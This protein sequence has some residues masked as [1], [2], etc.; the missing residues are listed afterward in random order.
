MSIAGE[1]SEPLPSK[2]GT[3]QGS[4]IGPTEY[5]IY[6]NDMYSIFREASVYQ[7]ADDTC[8][9]TA[10]RDIN[11][12]VGKI[13]TEFD[14]LCKWAHDIG[15]SINY[16]KTKV[17]HVC[18]PYIGFNAVPQVVA[19]NHLCLHASQ[20][21]CNCEP[22]DTVTSHTYLGLKI[23][24]KFNWGPHIE[25]ICS[26]LRAILCNISILK[27]KMPYSTLRLLYMAMA[28]SIINYG[29]SSYGRTY[30]TY[31]QKIYNI[32]VRI[33]K[34]IVPLKIKLKYRNNYDK[35][36][37]HCRIMNVFDKVKLAIALEYKDRLGELVR[38]DRSNRLR[39][40]ANSNHFTIP[41][42]QNI[43]GKRIWSYYLPQILNDF[44]RTTIDK[45]TS[46]PMNIKNIIK[47]LLIKGNS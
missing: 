20:A 25:H 10:D 14:V 33:L 2:Q 19:H 31:L 24:S 28:D 1:K 39:S 23:D 15:L 44:P 17:M 46:N 29:I 6:V 4:I 41:K 32:Q 43:Y 38:Y 9:I 3:A 18:S 8:L 30:I 12:A 21:C 26:K 45:I 22:L 13:Q 37:Q 42:C 47:N 35:L 36:F 27:H 34:T 5:L 16:Q 40:L 7:F 11:V